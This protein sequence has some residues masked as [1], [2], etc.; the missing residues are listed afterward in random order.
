LVIARALV[1]QP[2]LIVLD[3]ATSALDA[4][5]E[6]MVIDRLRGRGCTIVL[7]AHRLSTV[8]DAEQIVVMAHG[9]I[10]ETGTHAS[11]SQSGGLYRE[12][13]AT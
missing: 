2:R 6:S 12:L 3:E 8:R 4:R 5:T 11:L 13:M 7:V 10:V 9:E 1:R